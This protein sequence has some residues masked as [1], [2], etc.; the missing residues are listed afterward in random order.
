MRLT[1][2]LWKAT[3][4]GG[5]YGF[6]AGGL[7]GTGLGTLVGLALITQIVTDPPSGSRPA[8]LEYV[9]GVLGMFILSGLVGAFVG[10]FCG[11][12]GGLGMGLLGGQCFA[13]WGK[14]LGQLRWPALLLGLLGGW[15]YFTMFFFI[16]GDRTVGGLRS[17]A[18][19]AALPAAIAAIASY[20]ILQRMLRW[21][22]L[23]SPSSTNSPCGWRRFLLIAAADLA[24]G[25]ALVWFFSSVIPLLFGM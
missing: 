7:I 4:R 10:G 13:L 19:Y 6:L 12:V 2:L 15:L 23:D 17:A 18:L 16:T 9:G 14:R 1:E 24:V 21:L 8:T 25:A 22:A 11:S 20:N 5:G 3:W